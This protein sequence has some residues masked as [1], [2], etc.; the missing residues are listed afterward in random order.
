MTTDDGIRHRIW[1]L[2]DAAELEAIAA[3]LLPR[4]AT[5]A[6]GHHRYANYL[7]YQSKQ[8]AD[9][10]G[11]GPWDYGLTL[12]VDTTAFGPQ[13]HPIHRVIPSLAAADA[14][15]RA[16]AA[17]RVTPTLTRGDQLL[18]E[19]AQAGAAGSA[20]ALAD[21]TSAWLLTEPDP[22]AAAAALPAGRSAAWRALDVSL[23][24]HLLVARLWGL[25]DNEEVVGFRHDLPAAL[26]AAGRTGTALLLNPTPVQAVAAVAAAGDRMPRKSTL[27]TP[28]PRTGLLIRLLG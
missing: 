25:E 10:A 28:K 19:L 17:F 4:R 14:A 24:H 15:E 18:D 2:G 22:A 3:D 23:A 6:D 8:Y 21:E 9:G 11:P 12:L 20:F 27:F 1:A 5:I 13:V 7:Q 16:R 26:A